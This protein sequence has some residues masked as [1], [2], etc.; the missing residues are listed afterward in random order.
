LPPIWCITNLMR[1][2]KNQRMPGASSSTSTAQAA[3]AARIRNAHNGTGT[4]WFMATPQ[5]L[6]A[7]S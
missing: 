7:R 4:V 3:K 2:R 1:R 5:A 6:M